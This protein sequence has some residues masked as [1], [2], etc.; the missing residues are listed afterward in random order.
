[1]TDTFTHSGLECMVVRTRM[2]HYCG[3]VGVPPSHPWFGKGYNE[4]VKVPPSVFSRETCADNVGV[5]NLLCASDVSQ[6]AMDIVLA[7]DVHGGLTFSAKDKTREIWWFGFDCAHAGDGRSPSD[8]GW[9]DADFVAENCRSLADQ[10]ADIAD[11]E[12]AQ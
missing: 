4:K 8:D 3:Y 11:W 6:D 12:A 1:M 10:L 2:G 7:V 9:K 5:I